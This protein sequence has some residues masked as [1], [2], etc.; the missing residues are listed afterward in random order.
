MAD[1]LDTPSEPTSDD[2]KAF[3]EFQAQG[4]AR[5]EATLKLV[6]VVSGGMLTLSIGAILGHPPDAIPARLVSA[7]QWSWLFLF[8]SIVASLLTMTTMNIATFHMGVLWG[9]KI[10]GGKRGAPAPIKTWTPLRILN[11]VTGFSS[12]ICCIVGIALMARVA[13]GVAE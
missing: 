2:R 9:R 1:P 12:V 7:L 4:R 13:W 3:N 6:L 11:A 5:T 8:A 10:F